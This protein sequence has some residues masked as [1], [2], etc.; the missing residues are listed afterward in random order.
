MASRTKA[1][2]KKRISLTWPANLSRLLGAPIDHVLLDAE[3]FVV[4]AAA[5]L[6]VG[7]SDHRAVVAQL[8]AVE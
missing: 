3:R 5:I 7:A 1:V 4:D 8:S 2:T 6:D